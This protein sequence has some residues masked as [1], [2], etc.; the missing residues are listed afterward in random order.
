M[1]YQPVPLV[2]YFSLVPKSKDDSD[3]S[4]LH[5]LWGTQKHTEWQSLEEEYRCVI[6]AEAGAGKTFEMESRAK[7]IQQS[8]RAAFFIRIEDIEDGFENA[9]EVGCAESF[10]NWL[11]SH[12]KAWFF[13]DSVDEAR[14]ENPRAFEKAIRRFSLKI[15]SAQQRAHIYVS[16]RPYAWRA[17]T[18]RELLEQY[19]PFEKL[20][21]GTT[22]TE[23]SDSNEIDSDQVVEVSSALQVFILEPLDECGIRIFAEHRETPQVETLIIELHRA[24]LTTMAARPFDLESILAKWKTEQ[25]LDGRLELLQHNIELRL[26]EID[27]SRSQRQPLNRENALSGVRL[28]AAAVIMTGEPEFE[29]QMPRIQMKALMRN[30]F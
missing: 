24:N 6:L 8:G 21:A 18:D 17:R 26:S 19:L 11:K 9:F 28:L 29:F 15:K 12:E 5:S 27:P 2:R 7:H 3:E 1:M 20:L 30:L 10:D 22:V 4:E 14:L 23:E 16:S 25:K 13:L